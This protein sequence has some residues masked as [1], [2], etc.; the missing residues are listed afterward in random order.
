MFCV[1]SRGPLLLLDKHVK[2][3]STLPEPQFWTRVQIS[4]TICSQAFETWTEKDFG[5]YFVGVLQCY[6]CC[7]LRNLLQLQLQKLRV[8]QKREKFPKLLAH[9]H[10]SAP[11]PP[12]VASTIFNCRTELGVELWTSKGFP[13][14]KLCHCGCQIMR[15]PHY[16]GTLWMQYLRCWTWCLCLQ[17]NWSRLHFSIAIPSNFDSFHSPIEQKTKTGENIIWEC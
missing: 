9:L 4:P 6:K 1:V 16:N 17:K 15:F 2:E 7:S 5:T 3:K 14:I 12:R 8:W 10:C 13:Q 11:P